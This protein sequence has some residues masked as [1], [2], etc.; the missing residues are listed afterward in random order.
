MIIKLTFRLL[1]VFESTNHLLIAM[2]YCG[3]G[4]ILHLIKKKK[5]LA[6][7][8]AKDYFRQIIIGL[9]HCHSRSV[10]HRD[11]KLDNILLDNDMKCAKICDFGVSKIIGRG[12]KIKEQCGT[13]AYL[14][15]EIIEDNGYEAFFPD[16]WSLGI[17]L[18]AMVCGTVP[19]KAKTLPE[20]HDLILKGEFSLK[21]Y[22]V[23]DDFEDLVRK[24]LVTNPYKRITIPEILAHQ[25]VAV[26]DEH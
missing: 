2:E 1:E 4:D 19:F 7:T 25:W 22:D 10:L 5:R 15:P 13:P 24:M 3:G 23:T 9:A 26:S 16:L 17:L 21:E 20:L 8:E 14:A 12:H 18:F 6:E 11:I